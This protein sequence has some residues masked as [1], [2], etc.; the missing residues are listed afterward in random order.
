MQN[1][2]TAAVL[3]GYETWSVTWREKRRL[4]VFE[5]R[6]LREVFGAGRKEGMKERRKKQENEQNCIIRRFMNFD[7]QAS[8]GLCN[9]RTT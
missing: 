1:C 7:A 6:V 4:R 3:H 2:N 9:G 8:R 5:N